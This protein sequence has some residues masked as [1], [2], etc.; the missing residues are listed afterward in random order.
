MPNNYNSYKKL[1]FALKN[2]NKIKKVMISYQS[3][4]TVTEIQKLSNQLPNM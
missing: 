2:S 3:A 4:K 1:N